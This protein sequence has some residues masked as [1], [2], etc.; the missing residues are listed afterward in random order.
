MKKSEFW[1]FIK[2]DLNHS[3]V[4]ILLDLYLVS[5]KEPNDLGG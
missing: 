5:E 3:E 4:Y 2:P 1:R